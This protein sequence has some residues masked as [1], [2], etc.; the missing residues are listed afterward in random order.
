M[1]PAAV[2]KKLELP[3]LPDKG[4]IHDWLEARDAQDPDELRATIER[5]ADET[6]VIPL[7]RQPESILRYRPFPTDLLPEP[8]RGFVKA[9][10]K[11][12]GCD[13]SFL[14]LPMLTVVGAAIGTTRRIRLNRNWLA[15]SIL[16]TSIVG[17]SG[18]A[19]TP[20]FKLVMRS[21]KELQ[22]KAL[23]QHAEAQTRFDVEQVFY[24]KELAEW[25]RNKKSTDDPRRH[26]LAGFTGGH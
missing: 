21:V 23:E 5:L 7:G 8:V 22:R 9:G 18:T 24:D 16:W 11:A 1:T 10:S 26:T 4:D 13:P 12:I 17:E 6:P 14:A 15:P 3:G 20:A 2:V 19:K 25:K